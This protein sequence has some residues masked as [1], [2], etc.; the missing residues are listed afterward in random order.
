[1][2]RIKFAVVLAL[3]AALMLPMW[4]GS[5]SVAQAQSGFECLPTCVENDG[6][7]FVVT[8]SDVFQS[9]GG[10]STTFFIDSS[11][12]Q[13]EV[14]VFDADVI[15]NS[16][17]DAVAG[18]AGIYEFRIYADPLKTG[19]KAGLA[20]LTTLSSAD[21]GAVDNGWYSVTL[22][23]DA[24][25]FNGVDYSYLM[26]ATTVDPTAMS[27][28]SFKVR[29]NG[30]MSFTSVVTFAF[31]GASINASNII[32]PNFPDLTTSTYDGEWEFKFEVSAAP[33]EVVTEL[34]VWDGDLDHGNGI[35]ADDTDDPD[36]PN[37]ALPFFNE[38]NTAI[39]EGAQGA[40]SPPENNY[41]QDGKFIRGEA[42]TYD[43]VS[44][45]GQIFQNLNPSGN[46]EWEYFTLRLDTLSDGCDSSVAD[47]CVSEIETGTWS[48]MVHGVDLSNLNAYHFDVAKTKPRYLIGDT[49]WFDDN[50]NGVQDNGEAGVAGVVVELINGDGVTVV[51]TTTTS[52]GSDGNPV[53]YYDFDVTAG[54]YTTRVASSNFDGGGPLNGYAPTVE[55]GAEGEN[56]AGPDNSR[57][58]TVTNAD[59]MTYDY[60]Y[61]ADGSGSGVGSIGNLVWFDSNNNGTADNGETGINDVTVQLLYDA[62]GDGVYETDRG[63]LTTSTNPFVGDLNG[64]GWYLF[65][66]LPDGNY[67]LI[68]TDENGVLDDYNKTT[69]S[70]AG[71][72]LNSQVIPY[73]VTLSGGVQN[74]T[75]DFGYTN[76]ASL[77]D[78]VWF[79]TNGNGVQ[80]DGATGVDGVTVNLYV[81]A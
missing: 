12:P 23:Q 81:D 68:V 40:G 7:M 1:M 44:P 20:L 17:F 77:G 15:P 25:A 46:R 16:T 21:A 71:A 64:D 73:N 10:Q 39:F 70:N 80:D 52:D 75:G 26:E 2:R 54:S 3:L 13:L 76:L 22:P 29:A 62:N 38:A 67:Q 51:A 65:E 18:G 8:T 34:T 78:Y 59:I 47:Y 6:K 36:S 43:L 32:W 49:V 53:G 14:G 31:Y 42:V 50:G 30:N 9:L 63:T 79:D 58:Q 56:P 60:G 74:V 45:S 5:S 55:Y 37:D 66:G 19:N 27:L 57:R 48:V 61:E 28:N 11:A 41:N 72:D 69:G 33:D 35:D 4:S 24:G